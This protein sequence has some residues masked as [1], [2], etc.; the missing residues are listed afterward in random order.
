VSIYSSGDV[1]GYPYYF[2]RLPEILE[3]VTEPWSGE[4]SVSLRRQALQNGCRRKGSEPGEGYLD[5]T[6]IPPTCLAQVAALSDCMKRER[7]NCFI[8]FKPGSAEAGPASR[9]VLA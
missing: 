4:A 3:S 8:D 9:P 7:R 6:V 2:C 1:E 5:N